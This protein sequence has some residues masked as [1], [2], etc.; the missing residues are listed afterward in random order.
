MI[1]PI[2]PSDRQPV[3]TAIEYATGPDNSRTATPSLVTRSLQN[4]HD[5]G[6][7]SRLCQADAPPTTT[8]LS[9]RAAARA[10]SVR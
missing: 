6:P 9:G 3:P 4:C 5:G 7:E 2:A 8:T 1:T 10:S